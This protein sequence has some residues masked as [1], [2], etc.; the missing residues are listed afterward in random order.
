MTMRLSALA[1]AGL[2]VSGCATGGMQA[3]PASV[4]PPRLYEQRVSTNEVSIYWRC[5]QEADAVRVEGVVQNTKGSRVKF[6]E[7]EV[8][9]AEAAERYGASARV[10]LPDV[11]LGPNQIS[12]FSLALR[13]AG[14]GRR[15][16]LFYRYEVDAAMGGDTRPHF[17]ALD[18]CNP[19]QHRF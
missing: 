8:A 16:D 2:V 12:P 15:L 3:E 7:L 10:A 19:A 17:R 4:Y 18:V 13:P 1:C 9:E 11:I 6:M 5:A 14:A